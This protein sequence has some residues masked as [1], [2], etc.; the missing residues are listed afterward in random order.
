MLLW[1]GYGLNA[2]GTELM[3]QL[4]DRDKYTD[5]SGNRLAWWF[6]HDSD[7]SPV[8]NEN[9][10]V[11]YKW[12][13]GDLL[14]KHINE[15]GYPTDPHPEHWYTNDISW[16]DASGRVW[17]AEYDRTCWASTADNMYTYLMN[18]SRYYAWVYEDDYSNGWSHTWQYGHGTGDPLLSEGYDTENTNTG[19]NVWGQWDV[20]PAFRIRDYIEDGLPVS[21]GVTWGQETNTFNDQSHFITCYGIDLFS[22]NIMIVCSD[23]DTTG[24]GYRQGF[25]SGAY[26]FENYRSRDTGI[27]YT[28]VFFFTN[29]YSM[30][31][32]H[33]NGVRG[34]IL[35][36][37]QGSGTGGDM[38]MSGDSCAWDNPAN[39]DTGHIP[40][41]ENDSR[42]PKLWF[43]NSGRV[44]VTNLSA[45]AVKVIMRGWN[46]YLDVAS[47][48]RL[49]SHSMYLY[50]DA[51][52]CVSGELYAGRADLREGHILVS[53]DA[54][55]GMFNA[56]E[57]STV[58]V[59]D[60]GFLLTE[61]SLQTDGSTQ[62][63]IEADVFIDGSTTKWIHDGNMLLTGNLSIVGGYLTVSDRLE[64]C[65][66]TTTTMEDADLKVGDASV[67]NSPLIDMDNSHI[68]ADDR[69]YIPMEA[70]HT[71]INLLGSRIEAE[72]L[73]LSSHG[74]SDVAV[75]MEDDLVNAELAMKG[76][77]PHIYVGYLGDC[78]FTQKSGY[79]WCAAGETNYP[80][81]TMSYNSSVESSYTI[82]DGVMN[83]TD[84]IV[85]RSDRATFR[86]NGGSVRV[87]GDLKFMGNGSVSSYEFNGGTLRF[88][89]AQS[90][91]NAGAFKVNHTNIVFTGSYYDFSEF[92]LAY[93]NGSEV[94]LPVA[95]RKLNIDTLNIGRGGRGIFELMGG[96]LTASTV[97]VG[98]M[99]YG[100][101]EQTNGAYVKI[102]TLVIAETS[103][104]DASKY[105]LRSGTLEVEGT[106]YVG[107]SADGAIQQYPGTKALLNNLQIGLSDDPGSRYW[108]R[109]GSCTITGTLKIT[110]GPVDRGY[111]F[112][113]GDDLSTVL[114][115]RSAI[116]GYSG[117]GVFDHLM[118][119]HVVLEDLRIGQRP[120]SDGEY[121]FWGGRL[122][123]DDLIMTNGDRSAFYHTGGVHEN[124][125]LW[126]GGGGGMYALSQNAEL[127]STLQFIGYDGV[128]VFTQ[129]AGANNA[130]FLY[131]GKYAGDEG[132][133]YQSG[134]TNISTFCVIGSQP[135]STGT[136]VLGGATVMHPRHTVSNTLVLGSQSN[137]LGKYVVSGGG[138]YSGILNAESNIN[139]GGMGKGIMQM[140]GG[141]IFSSGEM[142]ISESSALNGYG[143]IRMNVT[144][145]GSIHVPGAMMTFYSNIQSHAGAEVA[146]DEFSTLQMWDHGIFAGPIT[147][148]GSLHAIGMGKHVAFMDVIEGVGGL[149]PGSRMDCFGN[150]YQSDITSDGAFVQHDSVTA[151]VN[152]VT[153]NALYEMKT[154][155]VLKTSTTMISGVFTNRGRLHKADTFTLGDQY[156]QFMPAYYEAY[157]GQIQVGDMTVG[158]CDWGVMPD[159]Y[160]RVHSAGVDITVTNKLTLGV[161]SRLVAPAGAVFR[162]TGSD[163]DI[164]N[165]NESYLADL[166]NITFEYDADGS[167]VD[168]LEVAS[169]RDGGF[170]NN[171]AFDGL[172]LLSDSRVQ[173]VDNRNNNNRGAYGE[174]C[175]FVE[176]LSI[177]ASAELD[178]NGFILY[179][180]GDQEV[181][182]DG[183]IADGRLDD[184]SL[185]VGV[186]LDAVYDEGNLW[187]KTEL[188]YPDTDE[189]GIPDHWEFVHGGS[190]TG[191]V[192]DG[193]SDGDGMTAFEE[194]IAGTQPTNASSCLMVSEVLPDA[195]ASN[196]VITW[197]VGSAT[198][199]LYTVMWNT[200]LISPFVEFV[201][202][203][204][205]AYPRNSYTDSIH[206]L[207]DSLYYKVNVRRGGE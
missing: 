91:P 142:I 60:N 70:V 12:D 153:V 101:F 27:L 204:N 23:G 152:T 197:T 21:L 22:E 180:D 68:R 199:S 181:A 145:A 134:G 203:S 61:D 174:E 156:M 76:D 155:T 89:G 52:L 43:E 57:G 5:T 81:M 30:G 42:L 165:S 169:A 122:V 100:R 99:D 132:F 102:D 176:S 150:V 4:Y 48:G 15:Y 110:D 97:R 93:S 168:A 175:L 92:Y 135:G 53:G 163:L 170:N 6:F 65:T 36:N 31:K 75:H 115:S 147:N 25:Y 55:L 35:N 87:Y 149:Y 198:S 143:G 66:A 172:T 196:I 77:A 50:N 117:E 119:T 161:A 193:D 10:K 201:D 69:L 192:A 107:T 32:C 78:V 112:L 171:F 190:I 26:G 127:S 121:N 37:W 19:A 20:N 7:P 74:S 128:G 179:T 8:T 3:G 148:D 113:D 140:D 146:I 33:V 195:V 63:W 98:Y 94:T 187:T 71:D 84:L 194:Y 40:C 108:Q 24:A 79:V 17:R 9:D 191:L 129:A 182:L 160:L 72:R 67:I 16:T 124:A 205:L 106:A 95:N 58:T 85:G 114:T 137:T 2:A 125:A 47:G 189:D 133:Y 186:A 56:I 151:L 44:A 45:R 162:M 188:S 28:N 82:E 157:S 158:H 96:A 164:I 49:T 34:F 59:E 139:V 18:T 173:L 54:E 141:D 130:E 207:H 83:L 206:S 202:G 105:R 73:Y 131:L 41:S 109:G 51:E 86:Q 38:A 123:T 14:T 1:V 144:N 184:N 159:C 136:Y 116:V 138:I 111:F 120:S 126:I 178:V 167:L 88:D 118:G 80:S 185:A 177:G 166:D 104:S 154:N 13:V 90:D 46:S 64:I 39:W 103:D 11:Y 62:S 183:Y 29:D 200:N